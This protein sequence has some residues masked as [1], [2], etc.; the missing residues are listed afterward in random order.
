MDSFVTLPAFNSG[1]KA[2]AAPAKD[3]ALV[4]QAIVD[5]EDSDLLDYEA[6]SKAADVPLRAIHRDVGTL[7]VQL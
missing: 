4:V 1:D 5:N 7:D 3:V 6:K 2:Q